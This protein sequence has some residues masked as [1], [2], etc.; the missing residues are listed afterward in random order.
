M[1]FQYGKNQCAP[2]KIG[3]HIRAVPLER[4]S[5]PEEVREKI[6]FLE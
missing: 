3:D 2:A 1:E 6:E 5:V 4:M